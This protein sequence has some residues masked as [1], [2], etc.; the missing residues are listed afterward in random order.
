MYANPR[1]SPFESKSNRFFCE[2]LTDLKATQGHTH[3]TSIHKLFLMPR[4]STHGRQV[5]HVS[6][7]YCTLRIKRI[8]KPSNE[9]KIHQ[10]YT[11]KGVQCPCMIHNTLHNPCVKLCFCV[12]HLACQ[13]STGLAGVPGEA[14]FCYGCLVSSVPLIVQCC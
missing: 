7:V 11:S 1:T 14:A 2:D 3:T 4:S 5:L 10:K 9:A 6:G 13:Q 12:C 8:P